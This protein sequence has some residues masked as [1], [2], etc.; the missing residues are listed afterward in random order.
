MTLRHTSK[1]I[2]FL[3]TMLPEVQWACYPQRRAQI[4]QN[5]G[6]TLLNLELKIVS[7]DLVFHGLVKLNHV[8]NL[9]HHAH[10][11]KR[12]FVASPGLSI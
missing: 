12:Y 4:I 3:D 2:S 9:V 10:E 7:L 5:L 8:H 1:L 6:T 11:I